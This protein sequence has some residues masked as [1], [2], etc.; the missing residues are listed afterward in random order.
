MDP[1]DPLT[2]IINSGQAFSPAIAIERIIWAMS[3][4][5]FLVAIL[6]SIKITILNKNSY[7]NKSNSHFFNFIKNENEKEKEKENTK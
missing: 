4:G 7:R 1:L 2:E 5:C 3:G 6:K